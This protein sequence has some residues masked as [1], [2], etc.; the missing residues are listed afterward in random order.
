[1]EVYSATLTVSFSS[2]VK[3]IEDMTTLPPFSP[4]FNCGLKRSNWANSLS[5]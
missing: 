1:M 3:K 4:K 5:E 2:V